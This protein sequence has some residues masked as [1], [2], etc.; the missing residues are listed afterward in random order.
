MAFRQFVGKGAT[1]LALF[2][3]RASESSSGEARPARVLHFALRAN[4]KNFQL[5]QKELKQRGIAF[6][7][8]DH[9]IAH[10]I[11]FRDP[12]GHN[13]EITTYELE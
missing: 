8:E 9:D 6:R 12:D 4:R 11:Y 3:L 2:P 7:F 1:G 10:S 5:A 13:L